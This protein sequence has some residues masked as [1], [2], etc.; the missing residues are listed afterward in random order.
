MY[1]RSCLI[2]FILFLVIFNSN[3]QSYHTHHYDENIESTNN[4]IY[5]QVKQVQSEGIIFGNIE[6]SKQF[7]TI[8]S[9]IPHVD[10]WIEISDFKNQLTKLMSEKNS[11]LTLQLPNYKGV[12]LKLD[13]IQVELFAEGFSVKTQDGYSAGYKS[14]LYYRGVL[15]GNSKSIVTMSIFDSEI[16]GMISIDDLNLIIQPSTIDHNKLILF[17]EKNIKADAPMECMTT[18]RMMIGAPTQG[19]DEIS[20]RAANDC[21]KSYIEC[22]YALYQNKG[23]N[24]TNTVNYITAVYNNVATLYANES[25]NTTISEVFVWT[26]PDSY[27]KT[28]SITA[29]NQ[30]RAARPTFNGNLAHLAAF[31]GNNLGGVAW[32]D[33]LCTNYNYAYSNIHSTYNNVPS[34]SWTVEVMTH[35]MGHNV[36]SNHTQWCGWSGGAIDNCYTPEGSC[37]PGPAPTNGGTIMS[38]C[39]LTSYGINFN[40]GFGPQPGN[41]IRSR[42]TAANCLSSSCGASCPT[43]A[44]L[45]ASNISNTS[46]LLS[47]SA[48]T[49]AVSYKLEYKL[50][51]GSTWTVI[52]TSNTSYNLTGLTAGTTYNARVQ[53]VCSSG[54][55]TYSGIISFTTSGGSCNTPTGLSI[56]GISSSSA[57]ASWSPVTGAISYNFQY[58]LSTNN[59]WTQINTTSISVQLNGLTP[60][61]MYDTRVQ[62]VCASGTSSF[63][64]IVS[65]TTSQNNSYCNSKGTSSQQEWIKRLKLNN[66]DRN[67]GSDNGYYN[68]TSL[69][70]NLT[71]GTSTIVNFQ[72]G[73]TG[74]Q[75]I[76]YWTIW[77]DFNKNGSFNDAGEKVVNGYSNSLNL[78]YSYINVPA[79]TPT[80]ITRMRISMKYGGSPSSCEIFAR[81]EVEDYGINIISAGNLSSNEINENATKSDLQLYPNP[82]SNSLNIHFESPKDCIS[83]ITVCD[84]T[85]KTIIKEKINTFS[86]SNFVELDISNLMNGNYYLLVK[87][88]EQ[89]L[90]R[91]FVKLDLH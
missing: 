52:S 4:K 6:L 18:E 19:H 2:L 3:G 68:A 87:N 25:I 23:S 84:L 88:T 44:G 1:R 64:A 17:D 71:R 66:V 80:G 75:R 11:S 70:A 86:G 76:L 59:T 65:F 85:G 16:Y 49:G 45:N 43:P 9:P 51:V 32:L 28:S 22:D 55:S 57:T 8:K 63:S 14:G 58:K 42:V 30:F 13:L 38:Y 10:E 27:S 50:A 33:V 82:S 41:K 67:S 47:W 12:E 24:I 20:S 53:T 78:L 36:G 31:G 54:S 77:I 79:T 73:I 5:Q 60:N 48:A 90:N 83:E 56:T 15:S 7:Q 29:L 61:T 81:G 74:T 40:N 37:P 69:V 34:Y 39:H 91:K 62:T 35:E 21:I 89:S 72:A 46:A 26:T